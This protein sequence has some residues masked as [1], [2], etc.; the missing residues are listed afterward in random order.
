MTDTPTLIPPHEVLDTIKAQGFSGSLLSKVVGRFRLSA[1]YR[2][3]SAVNAPGMWY[4]ETMIFPSDGT[5]RILYQGEGW[6][7]F[8]HLANNL[9]TEAEV[10]AFLKNMEESDD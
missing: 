1:I 7:P 3:T 4:C 6:A 5:S 10:E 2:E 8:L 9:N